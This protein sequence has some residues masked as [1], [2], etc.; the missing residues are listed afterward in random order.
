MG[1]V[2]ENLC[3][4]R[5]TV[6]DPEGRLSTLGAQWRRPSI[7]AVVIEDIHRSDDMTSFEAMLRVDAGISTPITFI[8]VETAASGGRM[9]KRKV[10]VA[11]STEGDR[12]SSL[13]VALGDW[14]VLPGQVS[15]EADPSSL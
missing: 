8:G 1:I 11:P 13:T 15:P 7:G 10:S 5:L 9:L 4:I 12:T 2:T 3:L 6:P 14:D